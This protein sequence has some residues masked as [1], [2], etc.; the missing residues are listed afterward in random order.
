M[1]M[2]NETGGSGTMSKGNRK[3]GSVLV[4]NTP[5]E[6]PALINGSSLTG[7]GKQTIITKQKEVTL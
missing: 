7:W 3:Q 4:T 2:K 6:E 5:T 1:V